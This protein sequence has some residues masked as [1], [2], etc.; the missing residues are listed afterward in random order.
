MTFDDVFLYFIV[1]IFAVIFVAFVVRAVKYGGIKAAMF[2]G[3]IER[4]VGEL[5]IT[6]NSAVR[7]KIK[8]HVLRH[9]TE[10]KVGLEVVS[11]TLA[12]WQMIPFTLSK[13]EAE[14]LSALLEKAAQE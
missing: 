5:A 11:K 14:Q 12:S 1:S 6:K 9:D 7:T 13:I 8:V 3:Y 10:R 4:T 2:G